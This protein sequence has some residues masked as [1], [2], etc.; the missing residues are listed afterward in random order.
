[1]IQ[2]YWRTVDET[3]PTGFQLLVAVDGRVQHWERVNTFIRTRPPLPRGN[4]W[5]H[6]WTFGRGVKHV[7][8]LVQGSYR[9]QLDAVVEDFAGEMWHW[10][11]SG[12]PGV[13]RLTGRVPG[14]VG[15]F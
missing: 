11:F 5:G 3:T 1:M 9:G 4:Q 15:G 10:V 12:T 8:S 6:L 13:W 2:D 7:W 14:V